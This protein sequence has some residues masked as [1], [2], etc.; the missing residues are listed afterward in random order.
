MNKTRLSEVERADTSTGL[1]G[2]CLGSKHPFGID[3]GALEDVDGAF[4]LSSEERDCAIESILDNALPTYAARCRRMVENLACLSPR[5]LLFGI[6]DCAI[7]AAIIALVGMISMAFMGDLERA[8]FAI[9]MLSPVF[10]ATLQ[11]LV[12]WKERE[13]GTIGWRAACR[14][15]FF[16]LNAVRTLLFGAMAVLL[17]VPLAAAAWIASSHAVSFWWAMSLAAASLTLFGVFSLLVFRF[18]LPGRGFG[19][20]AGPFSATAS[21]AGWVVL[22]AV[23]SVLPGSAAA[24]LAVPAVVFFAVAFAAGVIFIRLVVNIGAARSVEYA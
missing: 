1:R 13:S 2:G 21:M 19:V 11:G 22:G 17:T 4:T 3:A 12:A 5:A 20:A 8:V 14:V 6:E 9:I 10:F 7:A 24:L 16:E 18:L 15:T 23:L